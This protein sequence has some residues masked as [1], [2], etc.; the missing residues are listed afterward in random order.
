MRKNWFA[1]WAAACLAVGCAGPNNLGM[2][3]G[4]ASSAQPG[5][6]GGM[7]AVEQATWTERIT[8]PL[9]KTLSA[10]GIGRSK[11]P[12]TPLERLTPYEPSKESPELF[13]GMA[14]VAHRGGNV[15][16]ARQF[17]QKAIQMDPNHLEALLGAARM[18]DREG[19]L[20]VAI[21]LY[22]RAAAAHPRSATALNDLALC[23]A[24]C[25]E[26]P[27]A[28]QALES[29]ILLE[30]QKALYRNNV[31]KVLVELNQLD[32]ATLHLTAVHPPAI[33]HYNMGVLLAE[34]SRD[35]ESADYL[36]RAL[37]IDPQLEPARVVLTQKTIPASGVVGERHQK[38]VGAPAIKQ[39]QIESNDF[40]L[41][42]PEAVA[43]VPWKPQAS[44]EA[45]MQS[46]SAPNFPNALP[47]TP[48][49]SGMP[50]GDKPVLLLPPVN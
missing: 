2:P 45:V 29:A 39:V 36:A 9:G 34:R 25:G 8:A 37:A 49:T 21:M 27:L 44:V 32:R 17:Y 33:A 3:G 42:T 5:A 6:T 15:E 31:A 46:G 22:R 26:L 13:V 50:A 48:S 43:T 16:H 28:H 14:Q 19:R 40:V 41:P 10:V 11:A 24:R 20:D 35:G 7:P 18:E 47:S 23:H 12:S 4:M 38:M 30:P 1:A